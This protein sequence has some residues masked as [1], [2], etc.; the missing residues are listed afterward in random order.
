MGIYPIF[1]QTHMFPHGFLKHHPAPHG[2]HISGRER[3]MQQAQRLAAEKAQH[4]G[5]PKLPPSRRLDGNLCYYCAMDGMRMDDTL[6]RTYKKQWKDSPFFMGKL[7]INIYKW[8]FSIAMLVHQRVSSISSTCVNINCYCILYTYIYDV[9][10]RHEYI[11]VCFAMFVL[12]LAMKPLTDVTC[13]QF[14]LLYI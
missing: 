6:W 13:S 7:T 5:F 10:W 11:T 14:F 8:P 2:F 3:E 1:R 9:N 4:Q 12:R